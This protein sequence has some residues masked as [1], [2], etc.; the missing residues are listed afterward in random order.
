MNY[1]PFSLTAYGDCQNAENN[2]EETDFADEQGDAITGA[3]LQVMSDKE[4]ELINANMDH[5]ISHTSKINLE[6]IVKALSDC[7]P[8]DHKNIFMVTLAYFVFR[9]VLT[10]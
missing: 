1:L 10:F 4:K 6:Y 9:F 5:L 7:I 3:N 8:D 2:S